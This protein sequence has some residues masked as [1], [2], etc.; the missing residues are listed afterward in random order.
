M[1]EESRLK[2]LANT[3]DEIKKNMSDYIKLKELKEQRV[4]PT[5]EKKK[6][7]SPIKPIPLKELE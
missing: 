7:P 3:Y 5:L 1:P 4:K 6:K 2:S